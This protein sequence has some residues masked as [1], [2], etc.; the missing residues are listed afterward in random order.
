[1]E[2]LKFSTKPLRT[3]H[4]QNHFWVP[5][6]SRILGVYNKKDRTFSFPLT[7]KL[8]NSK[9]KKKIVPGN[10]SLPDSGGAPP[11]FERKKAAEGTTRINNADGKVV[12]K[13]VHK[14]VLGVL[15]NL[16][17]V[18]GEMFAAAGLMALGN[19]FSACIYDLITK[20]QVG[21]FLHTFSG[22]EMFFKLFWWR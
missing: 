4:F 20:L 16:P 14:R 21:L 7:C 10:I 12:F 9:G 18:I 17:L 6:N 11:L 15:S 22:V 3:P 2:M 19:I 8:K 13:K 5:Q 1:M